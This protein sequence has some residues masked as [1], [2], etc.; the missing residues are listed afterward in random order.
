MGL[1]SFPVLKTYG[2][3]KYAA[4]IQSLA[5]RFSETTDGMSDKIKEFI[6][7]KYGSKH[8][9]YDYICSVAVQQSERYKFDLNT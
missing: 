3:I 2:F 5:S 9:I 8:V 1:N 7:L 6:K 4:A